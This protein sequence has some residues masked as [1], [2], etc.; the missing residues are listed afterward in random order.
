MYVRVNL[1]P[2]KAD[3][4]KYGYED[5]VWR[6]VIPAIYEEAYEFSEEL[7]CVK[8]DGKYG[9]INPDGSWA[10]PPAF[11]QTDCMFSE[12]V[13]WFMERRDGEEK[14]GFIN[15][16]GSVA[17][18]PLYDEA[19]FF[20]EGVAVVKLDGKWGA[21][22]HDGSWTVEPRFDFI[23]HRFGYGVVHAVLD[24]KEGFIYRDGTW[25]IE[26]QDIL[27]RFPPGTLN[28]KWRQRDGL[29]NIIE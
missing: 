4:G 5:D 6:A 29:G 22:N 17:I 7:A 10:I 24:G 19:W 8:F 1:F 18:A 15:R 14:Y 3:N 21:V 9:F 28:G 13:A 11:E 25:A 27:S 23:A 26:P 2:M 12:G 16:D 20:S